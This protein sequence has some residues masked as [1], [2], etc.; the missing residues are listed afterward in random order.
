MPTIN[1]ITFTELEGS[2]RV[3]AS[4]D[5]IVGTRV[6]DCAWVD[7][8]DA[9]QALL[10]KI[11]IVNSIRN[12]L[13][14]P[15]QFP[16]WTNLEAESLQMEPVGLTGEDDT[17]GGAAYD[18][19]RFTVTY[20]VLEYSQETES[21][22][23]NN[24]GQFYETEQIDFEISYLKVPGN[25]FT[26]G[27]TKELDATYIP[28]PLQTRTYTKRDLA[29]LPDLG[30]WIGVVNDDTY[31]PGKANAADA[32]CLMFAGAKSTRKVNA[33]GLVRYDVSYVFKERYYSWN[34]AIDPATG[35]WADVTPAP[36]LTGDFTQIATG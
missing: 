3:Q 6:L 26:N 15:D 16:G 7:R 5:G 29:A 24:A 20:R 17:D 1:G 36:F 22:G 13:M 27:T 18:L 21:S 34:K 30:L 19:A 28:V 11:V 25:T 4:Q 31:P 14:P 2:C 23:D 35:Q 33:A 9:V 32:G 12:T 10:G 8:K